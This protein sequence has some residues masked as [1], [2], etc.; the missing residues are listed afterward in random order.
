MSLPKPPSVSLPSSLSME[1]KLVFFFVLFLY[2]NICINVSPSPSVMRSEPLVKHIEI[3]KMEIFQ[4]TLIGLWSIILFLSQVDLNIRYIPFNTSLNT[5]TAPNKKCNKN[6]YPFLLLISYAMI[7][8]YYFV[9]F[10]PKE[11]FKI[12][13]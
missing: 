8:E 4:I 10:L 1:S 3:G 6:M 12:R 7:F 11:F 9:I 13:F 5:L 2:V